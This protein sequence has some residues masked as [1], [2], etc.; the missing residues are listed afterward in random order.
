MQGVTPLRVLMTR[1]Y[2]PITFRSGA[3]W[4]RQQAIASE[5]V[6][7]RGVVCVSRTALHVGNES[8]HN[9]AVVSDLPHDVAAAPDVYPIQVQIRMHL[10]QNPPQY[11]VPFVKAC[12]GSSYIRTRHHTRAYAI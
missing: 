5:N 6:I 3:P 7:P 1:K 11:K 12:T 2:R 10:L 4:S 8:C 9:S